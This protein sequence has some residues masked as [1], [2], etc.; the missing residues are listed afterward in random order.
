MSQLARERAD[1]LRRFQDPLPERLVAREDGVS[2]ARARV[3]A[4]D[5]L[6]DERAYDQRVLHG[7]TEC[8]TVPVRSY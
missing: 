4:H 8:A 1:G 6:A 3:D 5:H 2:R 7:G